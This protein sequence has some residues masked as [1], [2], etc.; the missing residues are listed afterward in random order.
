MRHESIVAPFVEAAVLNRLVSLPSPGSVG[1]DSRGLKAA[2]RDRQ[3]LTASVRQIG[4]HRN[5]PP[6]RLRD[7]GGRLVD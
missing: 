1:S 2:T 6:P 4:D 7:E 3:P 5:R